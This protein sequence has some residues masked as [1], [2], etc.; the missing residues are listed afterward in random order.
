VSE[1]QRPQGFTEEQ[2]KAIEVA[3]NAQFAKSQGSPCVVCHTR[4]WT[5]QGAGLVYVPVQKPGAPT[6]LGPGSTTL[7]SLAVVCQT[8]GNTILLNIFI[9][10]L[11]EVFGLASSGSPQTEVPKSIE[12][13]PE[14]PRA[15]AS[16]GH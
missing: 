8:C 4:N 5:V 6:I 12:A 11:G 7:P 13:T 16:E 9:L 10:G 3:V 1:E 2:R 15:E 14:L